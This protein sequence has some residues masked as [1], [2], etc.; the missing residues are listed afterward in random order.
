MHPSRTGHPDP[1]EIA[2]DQSRARSQVRIWKTPAA[3]DRT[4]R[5]RASDRKI[6]LTYVT[7]TFRRCA[8]TTQL[9]NILRHM[10]YDR[11]D[12]SIITLSPED[13][14]NSVI[15]AIKPI[16]AKFYALNLSKNLNFWQLKK[17][18]DHAI[19]LTRTDIVHSSGLRGDLLA[20]KLNRDVGWIA[21]SRNRPHM[22]YPTKF[23]KVVGK[24]L[25]RVHINALR[26]CDHLVCC[27]KSMKHD[28]EKI[29][30]IS[31]CTAI[32]DGIEIFQ[33]TKNITNKNRKKEGFG[34][35]TIG[36]L[37]SGKNFDYLCDLFNQ[38]NSR[39]ATLTVVGDGP[40]YSRISNYKSENIHFVGHRDDVYPY[41]ETND[42]FISASL[43]EGLPNAVL[44]ALSMGCPC[45]L[46]DIGP[47]LEL[48]DEMPPGAV[49]IFSL[50]DPPGSVARK[51]PQY[52]ENMLQVS[53]EE[54]RE[55]TIE[56]YSARTMSL[57]YQTLYSNI[58]QS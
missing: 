2:S 47:H 25:A 33:N 37:K 36:N 19:D 15:D 22:E 7:S 26:R 17:R 54:I 52:V 55:R 11:F 39:I 28:F 43:F 56:R 8:P 35:V 24:G 14:K 9:M 45:L 5:R 3:L 49:Q 51:F 23:G 40:E 48:K 6:L 58:L 41:L 12:L 20:S 4:R 18:F 46:S 29:Y 1:S 21:T 50:S 16:P 31:D 57:R 34:F 27:S 44:E 32:P 30:G 53:R 10:D 42:F 13:K 38:I